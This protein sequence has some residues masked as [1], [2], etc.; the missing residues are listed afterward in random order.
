MMK[1]FSKYTRLNIYATLSTLYNFMIVDLR[2]RLGDTSYLM[3]MRVKDEGLSEDEVISK[4]FKEINLTRV[5]GFVVVI[6]LMLIT[7]LL[8]TKGMV[9]IP[10][11]T[12]LMPLGI[13]LTSKILLIKEVKRFKSEGV[14]LQSY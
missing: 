10:V 1:K 11:M 8:A 9:W 6:S 12:A 7:L 4:H 5:V 14:N 13:V 2:E 3:G